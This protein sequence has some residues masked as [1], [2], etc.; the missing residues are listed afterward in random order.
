[1]RKGLTWRPFQVKKLVGLNGVFRKYL[2]GHFG[3]FLAHVEIALN[4]A[5]GHRRH[6]VAHFHIVVALQVITVL[7]AAC[8][9]RSFTRRHI[10][11]HGLVR[12][13]VGNHHRCT[14]FAVHGQPAAAGQILIDPGHAAVD[15]FLAPAGITKHC[16]NR[17]C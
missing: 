4:F 2:L 17:H 1:M 8:D 9:H 16:V 3:Q 6:F 10:D 11:A 7:A 15:V 5:F 13:N 14:Q 12:L